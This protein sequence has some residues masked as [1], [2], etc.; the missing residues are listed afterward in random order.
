MRVL[1]FSSCCMGGCY[2]VAL[3]AGRGRTASA[4]SSSYKDEIHKSVL[5]QLP[6]DMAVS[7]RYACKR[8][9]RFDRTD[10]VDTASISDPNVVRQAL[11]CLDLARMAPSAFNT[12]PYKIVLVHSAEQKLALSR[13]CL[14]PNVARVRDSDCTAVFLADR[15]VLRTLPHFDKWLRMKNNPNSQS[16]RRKTLQM[17]FYIALFSSG[18]PVPRILAAPLSFLVRTLVSLVALCTRR[19]YPM[20]SLA[21]AETWSS[22]QVMLVA[23]TYMLACSARGLATIPME[24]IDAGGI[25]KVLKAPSR[26]SIPIIVSTGVPAKERLSNEES[27]NRRY[28]STQVIFEDSF[29][30]S[31]K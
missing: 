30:N 21:S 23:M 19:V 11:Q 26:Y 2:T 25:R 5:K 7:T 20:P 31:G 1:S 17:Q 6:L 12:Q 18:Y 3:I 22:K 29:G 8:F 28:P 24:G 16:S 27:Q 14:G 10:D 4:L 15:Q 9:K 13:Y